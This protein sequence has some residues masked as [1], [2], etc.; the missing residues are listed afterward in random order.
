MKEILTSISLSQISKIERKKQGGEN[1]Q[2][3]THEKQN[4]W[5]QHKKIKNIQTI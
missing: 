5:I 4:L 1:S 2:L 3:T